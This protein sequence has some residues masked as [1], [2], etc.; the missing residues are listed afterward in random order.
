MPIIVTPK[1]LVTLQINKMSLNDVVEN[2]PLR[3]ILV[4]RSPGSNIKLLVQ[5]PDADTKETWA[6]QIR[7]ILDMQGDF[8]R[9]K[10]LWHLNKTS[11]LGD[12][13]GF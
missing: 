10:S 4:D 12:N 5:A 2:E 6:L 9:G 11:V 1:S 7:Q 3:F 8:L 13:S